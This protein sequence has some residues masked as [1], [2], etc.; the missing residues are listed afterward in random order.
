MKK[1]LLSFAF[2]GASLMAMAQTA[3]EIIE[4][5]I[6][7]I[8]GK[9]NWKKVT[10]MVMVG[11]LNVMGRDVDVTITGVHLKGSRQDISVAGMNGYS[12]T[13]PNNGWNYMPFQGQTKPEPMTA[14]DV[15]EGLD[16]LDLQGNLLDYQAKGHTVELLGKE[17]VEGTE[18]FKLKITRKNSGEQVVF[19]DPATYYIIRTVTKRKAMGQEMDLSVDVSDY[20]EVNG[21]KV[22]FSVSQQ[23]GT[24]VFTSIKV[25]EAVDEKLFA[26]PS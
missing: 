23:F 15:K 20:R 5:H 26:N 11:K 9:E 1:L 2:F 12:F 4:K 6:A 3:D 18:C 16:D 14:D 10:S 19:I 21:I 17:D 24:V 13:T 25:N 8:G 22:P 7:A